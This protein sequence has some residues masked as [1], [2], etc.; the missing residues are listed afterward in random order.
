MYYRF[1]FEEI[2]EYYKASSESNLR[3]SFKY[4]LNKGATLTEL[5]YQEAMY[6]IL[7]GDNFCDVD[8]REYKV[9]I[10]AIYNKDVS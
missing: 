5:S 2:R 4:Y 9:T 1:D 10:E 3:A 8:N 7:S 6:C